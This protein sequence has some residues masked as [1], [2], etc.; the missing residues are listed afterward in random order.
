[1]DYNQRQPVHNEDSCTSVINISPSTTESLNIGTYTKLNLENEYDF[2][3]SLT[4]R[5][6]HSVD[7]C[8][9]CYSTGDE[10][11]YI[12][13]V[14]SVASI[15]TSSVYLGKSEKKKK[16]DLKTA[17]NIVDHST[18]TICSD[19]EATQRIHQKRGLHNGL[20]NFKRH[21]LCLSVKRLPPYLVNVLQNKDVEILEVTDQVNIGTTNGF[22]YNVYFLSNEK[23]ANIPSFIKDFYQSQPLSKFHKK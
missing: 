19:N 18:A 6:S 17:L 14:G 10:M 11:E 9:S 23:N 5:N 2:P 1:M 22:L 3:S 15:S 21:E 16:D 8:S 13:H 4:S 7:S 20:E 12:T